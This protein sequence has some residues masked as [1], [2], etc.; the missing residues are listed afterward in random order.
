[1]VNDRKNPRNVAPGCESL[2]NIEKNETLG[3]ISPMAVNINERLH[4]EGQ[5]WDSVRERGQH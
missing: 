2:H 3:T 4:V 1:M 5:C